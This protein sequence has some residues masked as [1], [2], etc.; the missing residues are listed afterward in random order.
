MSEAEFLAREAA[1]ARLAM[2]GTL[3]EIVGAP[4][5]KDG[6][7]VWAGKHPYVLIAGA[8]VGG[9]LASRFFA[10]RRGN[11]HQQSVPAGD[12]FA[13]TLKDLGKD[14]LRTFVEGLL[15]TGVAPRASADEQSPAP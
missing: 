4:R 10:P 15:V 8:A 12:G 11:G 6:W 13:G 9:A 3:R 5:G 7:Q 14:L 2:D 1:T